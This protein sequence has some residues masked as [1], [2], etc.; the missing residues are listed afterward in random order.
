[1][2][3]QAVRLEAGTRQ[4]AIAITGSTTL[5]VNKDQDVIRV[6]DIAQIPVGVGQKSLAVNPTNQ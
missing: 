3:G 4:V 2:S 6:I 1:M 5:V